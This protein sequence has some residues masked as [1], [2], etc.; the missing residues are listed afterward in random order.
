MWVQLLKPYRIMKPGGRPTMHGPGEMLHLKNKDM[1]A[2]L[3]RDGFAVDVA[4]SV[5]LVPDGAGV[6]V[7]GHIEAMPLWIEG[8]G[9]EAKE[10]RQPE[11]IY[12]VTVLWDSRYPP[13]CLL[14]MA[15]FKVMREFAWDLAVP[16]KSYAKLTGELGNETDREITKRLIHDLRVPYYNTDLMVIRRNDRTKALIGEWCK[17]LSLGGDECLAFMRAVYA[18]RPYLL[19][20]PVDAIQKRPVGA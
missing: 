4:A 17:E 7:R 5:A 10:V 9:M 14:L 15:T 18:T 1:A 12:P 3:I 20:L 13:N 2:Q 19:P 11:L 6:A 8:M 16:I